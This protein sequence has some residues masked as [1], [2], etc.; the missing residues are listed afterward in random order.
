MYKTVKTASYNKYSCQ[1]SYIYVWL[2]VFWKWHLFLKI[3]E[4][5]EKRKKF[6]TIYLRNTINGGN[7]NLR[8]RHLQFVVFL[9]YRISLC[10]A[11][12]PKI[13][14][15]LQLNYFKL[16]QK[17]VSALVIW[18]KF[19]FSSNHVPQALTKIAR[20]QHWYLFPLAIAFNYRI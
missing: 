13:S 11:E 6:F 3:N 10:L 18:C 9:R 15:S 8:H 20:F 12:T 4:I 14:H 5:F 2:K 7:A 19:H 1:I 16:F 17:A